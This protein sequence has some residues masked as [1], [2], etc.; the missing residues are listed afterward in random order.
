MVEGVKRDLELGRD[1]LI[2]GSTLADARDAFK[3]ATGS[4]DDWERVSFA[5]N[6]GCA[7]HTG[8]ARLW[9]RSAHGQGHR[10]VSVDVAVILH[11]RGIPAPQ[12]ASIAACVAASP[13][14]DIVTADD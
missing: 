11:P 3:R 9:A 14:A 5:S 4:G 13:V 8:G 7:I 2:V 6:E 12:L 10:G 1:V